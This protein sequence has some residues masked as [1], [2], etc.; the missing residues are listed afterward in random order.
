MAQ[1]PDP[2]RWSPVDPETTGEELGNPG[3]TRFKL[4]SWGTALIVLA[5]A[6]FL[7]GVFLF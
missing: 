2:N 1:G 6:A 5:I 4:P 7:L 3:T